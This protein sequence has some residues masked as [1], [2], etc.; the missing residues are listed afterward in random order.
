MVQ[1]RMAVFLH[2]SE[3]KS[4]AKL[5]EIHQNNLRARNSLNDRR[6]PPNQNAPRINLPK[7]IPRQ[8]AKFSTAGQ[9]DQIKKPLTPL[10]GLKNHMSNLRNNINYQNGEI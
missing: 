8:S 9:C 3:I 5:D 7:Q 6:P 10:T 2:G 1:N 4:S